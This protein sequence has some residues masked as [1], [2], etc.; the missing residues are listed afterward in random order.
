[1]NIDFD[2]HNYSL[3]KKSFLLCLK[4]TANNKIVVANELNIVQILN[5]LRPRKI[6]YN[7]AKKANMIG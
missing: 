6:E 5:S 3:L 7:I 2:K 4:A 1:M